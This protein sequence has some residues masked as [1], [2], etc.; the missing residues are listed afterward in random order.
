MYRARDSIL[1]R[2]VAVKLL[3]EEFSRDPDRLSRFE[4]ETKLLASLNHPYIAQVYALEAVVGR[5]LFVMELVDG[6][7]DRRERHFGTP[8]AYPFGCCATTRSIDKVGSQ[9]KPYL[10]WSDH[11][12]LTIVCE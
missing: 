6:E 10:A 8:G 7:T 11:R 5:K 2:D 12:E 3:P 1:G 9:R 4:R